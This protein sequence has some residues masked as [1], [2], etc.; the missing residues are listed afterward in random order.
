MENTVIEKDAAQGRN[1]QP[2]KY[3]LVKKR[4]TKPLFT[5]NH[6]RVL[7]GSDFIVLC[8]TNFSDFT[9]AVVCRALRKGGTACGGQ[10]CTLITAHQAK[11]DNL[12]PICIVHSNQELTELFAEKASFVQFYRRRNYRECVCR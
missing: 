11:L 8:D 7:P 6:L 12:V 9:T 1:R 10:L 5:G 4:G 3:S 2:A